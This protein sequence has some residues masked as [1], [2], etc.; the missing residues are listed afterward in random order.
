MDDPKR[1]PENRAADKADVVLRRTRRG[2]LY[3]AT[4]VVVTAIGLIAALALAA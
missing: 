1:S 2:V 4:I 3:A